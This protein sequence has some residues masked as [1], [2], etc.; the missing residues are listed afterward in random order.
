MESNLVL[1][2]SVS[3]YLKEDY[4][5][6]F[7]KSKKLI[8]YK[9][10]SDTKELITIL[11]FG[12]HNLGNGPDFLNCKVRIN[13]VVWFG[14]VEIHINSE[15]W[16]NHKHH[17][18]DNFNNVILHVVYNHNSKKVFDFPVLELKDQIEESAF[19]KMIDFFSN[20]NKIPCS[21]KILN[22]DSLKMNMFKESLVIDRIHHK[23][24]K[25]KF[26]LN[27]CNNNWVELIH[28][29]FF[30]AFGMKN[31]E[32]AMLEL[33][34]SLPKNVLND[35]VMNQKAK[36]CEALLLGQAGF[37]QKIDEFDA[38]PSYFLELKDEYIYLRNKYNL[39]ETRI[40]WRTKSI[41]PI[42]SPSIRIVQ[43]A[44]FLCSGMISFDQ[45]EVL[46]FQDSIKFSPS[47]QNEIWRNYYT[48]SKKVKT[49]NADL[50][51]SFQNHLKINVLMPLIYLKQVYF[52]GTFDESTIRVLDQIDS[53]KNSIVKL[54][55]DLGL[56]VKTAF[57]SQAYL[58]LKKEYC[59]Q[60]KCLSC[61]VGVN[62]LI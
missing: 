24:I 4:L 39:K 23:A 5:H 9:L 40:H 60:K 43:M 6:F 53:E 61:M 29:A 13:D 26:F 49:F 15:D 16:Y 51:I 38:A 2:D 47:T 57:D 52:V 12:Q 56:E 19:F 20:E 41:R 17:N 58:H 37:L 8:N 33:Y 32:V 42:N 11:D 30:L 31:N 18:D 35:M 22:I 54:F 1:E 46:L 36:Q 44:N 7:W 21:K 10:F 55:G 45:L 62:L 50:S 48:L 34:Q 25:L 59:N 3:Q 28:Y 14:N 27:D